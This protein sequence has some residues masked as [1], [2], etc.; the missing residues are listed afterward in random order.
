MKRNVRQCNQF[1]SLALAVIMVISSPLSAVAQKSKPPKPVNRVNKLTEQQKAIHLLDRI[2]FG[3]RFDEVEQ[4][5]Q[6]GWEK[7]LDQQ[8]HPEK[9]ADDILAQKLQP[10]STL[11][12]SNEEIAKVY[13]PPPQVLHGPSL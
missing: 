10:L 12:M 6:M 1:C 4:V 11:T 3:P 8:L 13:E 9:I 5:M 7:Y 2:T